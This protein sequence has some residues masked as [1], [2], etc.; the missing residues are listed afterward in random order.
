MYPLKEPLEIKSSLSNNYLVSCISILGNKQCL[1]RSCSVHMCYIF[2]SSHFFSVVSVFYLS[3][4]YLVSQS[5][6]K[7]LQRFN[8]T[9]LASEIFTPIVTSHHSPH[10]FKCRVVPTLPVTLLVMFPITFPVAC[11]LVS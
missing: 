10:K 1:A 2:S 6:G 3:V 4:I 5:E 8:V 11:C 9:K 7:Y